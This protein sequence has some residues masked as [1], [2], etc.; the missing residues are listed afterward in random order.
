MQ[1][2]IRYL[3]KELLQQQNKM[4]KLTLLLSVTPKPEGSSLN[5]NSLQENHLQEIALNESHLLASNLQRKHSARFIQVPNGNV[6]FSTYLSHPLNN[7]GLGQVIKYDGIL[8]NEMNAYN[9]HTGVFTCPRDGLYL[10]AFFTAV[11][12]ASGNWLK[13]VVDDR[14]INNALS[15]GINGD[16]DH[17]GGNV[18][19]IRLTTGQSVWTEA[20]YHD[21]AN[22]TSTA[23]FRLVTFSGVRLGD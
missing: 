7:I 18:A 4:N 21:D 16:D 3:S 10:I 12:G 17:Q 9:L 5:I 13:L 2:E 20:H 23:E 11:H 14:S 15:R 19:I 8:T 6:A 1:M 22:L